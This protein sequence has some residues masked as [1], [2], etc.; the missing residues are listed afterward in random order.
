MA[1]GP[2]PC[3][4][5]VLR[6]VG[7]ACLCKGSLQVPDSCPGAGPC[8]GRKENQ[9][10]SGLERVVKEGF[11]GSLYISGTL[12]FHCLRCRVIFGHDMQVLLAFL[13]F[14]LGIVK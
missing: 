3:N 4:T 8:S 13:R 2:L 9:L 11:R 6:T 1:L 5:E 12:N 10:N 7:G 14:C